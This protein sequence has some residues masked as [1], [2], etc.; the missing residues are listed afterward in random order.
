M[1]KS[2]EQELAEKAF[3]NPDTAKAIGVLL[4]VDLSAKM[5][6]TE[7]VELINNLEDNPTLQKFAVYIMGMCMGSD[8]FLSGS[9]NA[10]KNLLYSDEDV[11]EKYRE[12]RDK[13]LKG[14]F[15]N[16]VFSLFQV[17]DTTH[18]KWAVQ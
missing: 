1:K 4:M 2:Q 11:K 8:Q 16:T 10:M 14:D 13:L 7:I 5:P 12:Y 9:C 17:E 6:V 3:S 15:K 18:E